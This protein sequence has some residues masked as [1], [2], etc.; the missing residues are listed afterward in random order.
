MT[1]GEMLARISSYELTEWMVYE[2]LYGPLASERDDHLASLL[3][4]V[5]SNA[6]RDKGKAAQPGD[7]LPRWEAPARPEEVE[8]IGDDP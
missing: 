5:I 6:F 2:R 7:F 8:E 1:K 3:A 4:A